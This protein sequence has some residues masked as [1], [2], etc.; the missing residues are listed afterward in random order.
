MEMASSIALASADDASGSPRALIIDASSCELL[1]ITAV[2]YLLVGSGPP[3]EEDD[4][5]REREGQCEESY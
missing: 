4:V 3:R 1:D 5:E 2:G